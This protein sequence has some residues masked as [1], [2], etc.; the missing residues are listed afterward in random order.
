MAR[1]KGSKNKVVNTNKNKKKTPDEDPNL[2]KL[3]KRVTD[4]EISDKKQNKDIERQGRQI[5]QVQAKDKL[6]IYFPK[7]KKV[8]NKQTD[9]DLTPEE[10]TKRKETFL[11]K[12]L[13]ALRATTWDEQFITVRNAN[14]KL[15][16]SKKEK[17]PIEEENEL[18]D[19]Y[20][21]FLKGHLVQ[22]WEALKPSDIISLR[23]NDKG[24][25]QVILGAGCQELVRLSGRGLTRQ[26]TTGFVIKPHQ[27][28]SKQAG[29]GEQSKTG[30]GSAKG[31][32]K[33]ATVKSGKAAASQTA[34]KKKSIPKK[35]A[36]T[37]GSASKKRAADPDSSEES[38]ATKKKKKV[39]RPSE[40]FASAENEEEEEEEEYETEEDSDEVEEA[41]TTG[42][43][44]EKTNSGKVEEVD[45]SGDEDPK[46]FK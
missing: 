45:T 33:G 27:V 16:T 24:W 29:K 11:K 43:A 32:K 31:K 23:V 38:A 6:E 3:A 26:N 46:D 2:D 39:S 13:A 17:R 14:G 19:E 40:T 4:L 5:L 22:T 36:S 30:G 44:E 12:T 18:S 15:V 28:R 9:V 8:V 37:K 10:K 35:A 21:V 20:L 42:K 1:P 25:H 7:G 41:E 34:N